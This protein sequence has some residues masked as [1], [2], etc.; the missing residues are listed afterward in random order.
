MRVVL[1]A[2]IAL[3]IPSVVITAQAQDENQCLQ[4]LTECFRFEDNARGGCFQNT[5]VNSAC[6]GTEQG[7][8]ASKRASLN[9]ALNDAAESLV[10]TPEPTMVDSDCIDN[11]DSFWL[12][13]LVNGTTAA[14]TL[15]NLNEMLDGCARSAGQELL[16]P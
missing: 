9:G 2:T 16:R 15:D 6:R 12:G 8:L 11:F 3:C 1:L 13:N 4:D 5:A 7:Q 14:D 10:A